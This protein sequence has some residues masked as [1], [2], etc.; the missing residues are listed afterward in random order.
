MGFQ[1]GTGNYDYGSGNIAGTSITDNPVIVKYDSAG[2][3]LWAKTITDGTSFSSFKGVAVDGGD[4]YAVGYQMGTGNYNYGSGNIAGT[5]SRNPVIVK[6][7]SS[8]NAQ[9]AKTI[10]AGTSF[11]QFDGVAVVGSNVY[12]VGY[13]FGTGNYNYGNGNIRGAGIADNSVVVR[14]DR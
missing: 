10:T 11:S 2:N 8:G 13:Q 1:A 3:A 6:Y 7:D 12:A 14:Y 5:S 9:W 4:I